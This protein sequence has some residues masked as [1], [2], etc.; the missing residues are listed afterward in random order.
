MSQGCLLVIL[1]PSLPEQ[2]STGP[3]SMFSPQ[4]VLEKRGFGGNDDASLELAWKADGISPSHA[5]CVAAT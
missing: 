2:M 3:F 1:N 5:P 4:G